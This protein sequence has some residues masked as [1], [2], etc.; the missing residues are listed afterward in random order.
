M[1]A[2]VAQWKWSVQ[3][4]FANTVTGKRE[5]WLMCVGGFAAC[6]VCRKYGGSRKQRQDLALGTG[7]FTKLQNILRHGNATKA[8][9]K[10]LAKKFGPQPGI[11]WDH[12]LAVQ[13]WCRE[14]SSVLVPD[15]G[16]V[17]TESVA[18]DR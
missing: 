5:T 1:F 2:L 8:Q 7:T 11:N 3:T 16:A 13:Q 17:V 14:K 6:K 4:S 18:R 9:Q 12:E 15:S 10:M